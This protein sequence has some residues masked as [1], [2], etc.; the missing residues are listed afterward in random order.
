MVPW[1]PLGAAPTLSREVV[2]LLI[3]DG[4]GKGAHHSSGAS[5]S[6]LPY[7]TTRHW[8]DAPPANPIERSL[9]APQAATTLAR[10]LRR[11]IATSRTIPTA[12]TSAIMAQ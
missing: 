9:A 6:L 3:S 11:D 5:S 1:P 7:C 10:R 8:S 4:D 12:S 2:S